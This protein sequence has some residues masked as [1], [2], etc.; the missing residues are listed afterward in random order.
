M[1]SHEGISSKH[2]TTPLQVTTT[3]VLNVIKT[4]EFTEYHLQAFPSF[5]DKKTKEHK[6][7]T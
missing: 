2:S 6:N 7:S 5:I 4:S 3:T 1:G